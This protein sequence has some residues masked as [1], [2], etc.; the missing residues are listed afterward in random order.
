MDLE[1][2]TFVLMQLDI[3]FGEPEKNFEHVATTFADANLKSGEIVI[4]PEMWN[5]AYDLERLAEIA[6]EEGKRTQ[7]LL[8]E[9]ARKYQ[10]TIVGGS[11]ARKSQ[12]KFYNTM[13]VIG[14]C[15]QLL[16]TYDKIHLFGLMKE[17]QFLHGGD[18]VLQQTLNETEVGFAICYDLRFPEMFR[19]LA[20]AGAQVIIVPA[21]W[22][23]VRVAHWHTLLRARGI[24]NQLFV[25]GVNRAGKDQ[26]GLLYGHSLAVDPL[27]E[28]ILELGKEEAVQRVVIDL[29]EIDRVRKN[30]PILADRRPEIY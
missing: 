26:D 25:I 3:V 29:A 4:L 15:G 21:Q 2:L 27:G 30:M 22:P 14:P 6:D 13:Y 9:L 20:L 8:S 12:D 23:N 5:T 19:K 24:E 7:K 1:K 11:I 10:V 17:D 16:G 18:H 28:T